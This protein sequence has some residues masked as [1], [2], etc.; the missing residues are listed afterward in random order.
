MS[1]NEENYQWKIDFWENR[2]GSCPVSD[3]LDKIRKKDKV[4]YRDIL[5]KLDRLQEKPIEFIFKSNYLENIGNDLYEL[6]ITVPKKEFR[7]L[8]VLKNNLLIPVFASLHAFHKK[9]NK[10]RKREI[11]IALERK[12]QLFNI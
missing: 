11:Q 6:K 9:D 2:N 10:L 8:G 12:G 7:M 3:F 5:K 1:I 4:F